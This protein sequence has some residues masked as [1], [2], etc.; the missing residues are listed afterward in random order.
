MAALFRRLP[1]P[2][3]EALMEEEFLTGG[4]GLSARERER[5]GGLGVSLWGGLVGLVR[6]GWLG[7]GLAQLVRFPFFF[8]FCSVSFSFS[9]FLFSF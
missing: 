9:V 5:V 8:F 1:T 7:L 4:V 3:M 6:V 2:L